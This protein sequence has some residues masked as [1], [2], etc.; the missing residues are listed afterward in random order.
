MANTSLNKR[1]HMT[2]HIASGASTVT[3][4]EAKRRRAS[5]TSGDGSCSQ[6]Q[7]VKSNLQRVASRIPLGSSFPVTASPT[8]Q[9]SCHNHA[10]LDTGHHV[11]TVTELEAKR[12]HAEAAGKG[13][14]SGS[15][16]EL[17]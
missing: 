12:L 4:P 8:H 15:L 6:F 17:P 14:L 11:S 16:A 13:P 10:A 9:A 3:E 1:S 2:C 5:T 7:D